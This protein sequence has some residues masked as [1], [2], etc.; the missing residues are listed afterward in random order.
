MKVLVTG[1]GGFVGQAIVA[2]LRQAGEEVFRLE[3]PK[4]KSNENDVAENVFRADIGDC[5]NLIET[6][7]SGNI[8][9]V[10][11]VVHSAGLA[12]QFGRQ[13][14]EDFW[15]INVHGSENTARLAAVLKARH[16]ILISSVAVYG[17][18]KQ[19]KDKD[20]VA[21]MSKTGVTEIAECHPQSLYA[22]SKLE[23]ENAVERICAEND[24]ALTILRLATV[25]G[26]ED[27]GNVA[28]LVGRIDQRLFVWIGGGENFKSLIYKG[29]AAQACL[30]VLGRTSGNEIF[31]VT[32]E[33]VKMKQVVSEISRN[34]GKPI[35]GVRISPRLLNKIFSLN[36][37][38]F[39]IKKLDKLAATVEKWLSDDVFSGEKFS[40][41]YGF[42]AETPIG[43][44]LRRQVE[45]YQKRR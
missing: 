36:S 27:K 28:R 21:G 24:I 39:K 11:V 8:E 44:A 9:T 43:E 4:A 42:Q 1:A 25:I 19:G 16:F 22:Q 40:R 41:V 35:S 29:D 38:L 2:E 30:K 13:C 14:K 31:N 20:A 17:E 6:V 15:R 3:S 26:E 32:G 37:K 7:R 34:L 12:H 33:P 10:D 45:D 23:A 5:Q 18:R